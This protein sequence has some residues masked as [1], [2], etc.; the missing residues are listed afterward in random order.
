MT[1]SPTD[2]LY[3]L[4][5]AHFRLLDSEQGEPLRALLAVISGEVNAVAADIDHLYDNWFI[6]TCD[7]WLVPYIGDLLGVRG[8]ASTVDA[9]TRSAAATGQVFSQRAFVANTVAYRRRKGTAAVLE[10]LARDITGWPAVAVEFFERLVTT[11]HL[12]HVRLH[13][14]ATPSLRDA[15]PL[16][17]TAG[18]FDGLAHTV[19]VRHI[20]AP[21]ARGAG[22]GRHNIPHVGIFLLTTE[23]YHLDG[24]TPRQVDPADPLR[25]TFSPLG[26]AQRLFKQSQSEEEIA[27]RI[28]PLDAPLPL[29]RRLMQRHLA[30]CYGDGE[31]VRSL[32][33]TVDGAPIP[34]SEV[35]VCNL[36]DT[37]AGAWAHAAK[38][39]RVAIDPELGRIAFETPPAGALA[40]GYTY[41]FPGD[42]GGGPY[43]RR[44][45]LKT[46]LDAFAA[47][48]TRWQ[49]GVTQNPAA[50]AGSEIVATLGEAVTAWNALPPGSWG[51]IALM[52]NATYVEDLTGALAIQM[53][54]DSHLL[55]VAAGWPAAD[56]SPEERSAGL[57]SPVGLRPHL[58][59]DIELVGTAAADALR[60]GTLTLNGLLIEGSVTVLPGNLGAL[61]LAHAT[62]VP[63]GAPLVVQSGALAGE[64]NE[65]LRL[66]AVRSILPALD[67]P[68][69][70][71]TATLADTIVDGDIN[72]AALE[73]DCCTLLGKTTAITLEASNSILTGMV[74][75]ERRQVGCVRYSWLPFL[76]LSPRRYRC[77]SASSA[78]A[79]RI[80][81]HFDSA[82]YGDDAYARLAAGAPCEIATGADDE[83]EMGVWHFLHRPQR[84]AALRLALEEYLRFG[85][86]AGI[87][88]I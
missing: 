53:P 12:N 57:I 6:E 66:Q 31:E 39:G 33:I 17:F 30:Q 84:L 28:Q 3:E 16:T 79:A 25:Y 59:G 51:I 83:G 46:W 22:R 60:P 86:E 15:L 5:P 20:D 34:V 24:V 50:G 77:Q 9:V 41:G 88:P 42:L 13:S 87:L 10:Q 1:R 62:V 68:A 71:A 47:A 43:D 48:P 69:T 61:S 2:A 27:Q 8:L 64:R 49:M 70:M 63:G 82:I 7:E 58:Q 74:T 45:G 26:I 40:V 52:D 76:S 65:H 75:I 73:I 18:P 19:D 72:A 32:T 35:A 56:E 14:L 11:Q 36:A 55:V 4:L 54:A 80:E 67:L 85:L 78:T 38:P 81:P 44:A 37:A 21:S 29:S 23:L